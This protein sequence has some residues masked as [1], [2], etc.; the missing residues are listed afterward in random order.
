MHLHLEKSLPVASGIGG[1][2]A[3]AAAALRLLKDLWGLKTESASLARIGLELGADVPMCLLQRPL[4]ARG[5]GERL[6]PV[7]IG[8]PLELVI[9]NP[10]VPVSTPMV[11]K[12]LERRE[13]PPLPS[14][15][16]WTDLESLVSW[17]A[18]TRNDLEPPAASAVPEIRHSIDALRKA[19]ALFAR[20]SGSGASCF[21]IFEDRLSAEAAARGIQDANPGWF[22]AAT[23]TLAQNLAAIDLARG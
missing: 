4:I 19:D 17:L 18:E 12:A 14:A 8:F 3:D 9:V 20:M 7:E 13:N 11:F 22:V 16:N 23:A 10:R 21:G 15:D 1:G 6:A 2:S 5:I